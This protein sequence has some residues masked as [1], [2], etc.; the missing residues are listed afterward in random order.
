MF[1]CADISELTA[2]TGWIPEIVFEE[3][4]RRIIDKNQSTT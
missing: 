4:I 3:G 2:D 1:L